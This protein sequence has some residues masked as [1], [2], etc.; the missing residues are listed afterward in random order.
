MSCTITC[1]YIYC[2][3]H[4][5][6][7]IEWKDTGYLEFNHNEDVILNKITNPHL[8]QFTIDSIS[9]LVCILYTIWMRNSIIESLSSWSQTNTLTH[10]ME[11]RTWNWNRLRH[12]PGVETQ[13]FRSLHATP[14]PWRHLQVWRW[15]GDALHRST[16][17]ASSARAR[18]SKETA[19]RT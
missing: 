14:A 9:L 11:K 17:A 12:R 18:R 16:G 4:V 2:T 1:E 10:I 15:C 19:N 3:V 5:W 7:R 6:D 13:S 8:N